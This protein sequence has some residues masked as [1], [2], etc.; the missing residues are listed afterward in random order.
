MVTTPE[1]RLSESVLAEAIAEYYREQRMIPAGIHMEAVSALA[2]KMALGVKKMV[3]KFRRTWK[4]SPDQAKLKGLTV[5]KQRLKKALSEDNLTSPKSA[6]AEE[7]ETVAAAAGPARPEVAVAV[8]SAGVDWQAAAAKLLALRAKRSQ[9]QTTNR[10][11]ATPARSS[12]HLLP[13]HVVDTLKLPSQDVQPFAITGKHKD[14]IAEDEE[15]E[16]EDQKKKK[17]LCLQ[18]RRYPRRKKLRRKM[19]SRQKMRRRWLCLRVRL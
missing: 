6:T 9:Q 5:L 14:D 1:Q 10:P 7:V 12:K 18:Q 11:V 19:P 15:E 3:V 13:A 2:G 4:E 17:K 8:Q 16:C